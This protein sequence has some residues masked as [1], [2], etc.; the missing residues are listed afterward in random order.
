MAEKDAH[1][2]TQG[3]PAHSATKTSQ[4]EITFYGGPQMVLW[5]V[6]LFIVLSIVFATVFHVYSIE[7]L[8]LGAFLCL[9]VLWI[10][11]RDHL[12]FWNCMVRGLTSFGQAKLLFVFMVIGIF[13]K[14]LMNGKI[15]EGLVW[16]SLQW[17]IQG[18]AFTA[19]AF[20]GTAIVSLGCG[21]PFAAI[22]TGFSI[23]YAPGVLLGSNPEILAGAIIGGLYFGDTLAP[24]SQLT[25]GAL[26]TQINSLTG[27]QADLVRTLKQRI[28]WTIAAAVVTLILI[29]LIP[30]KGVAGG[31]TT[32]LA[33]LADPKGLWMLV[34]IAVVVVVCLKTKEIL[35]GLTF[36]IITGFG[37]GM[38]AG[39]FSFDDVI[40]F[41]VLEQNKI[42]GTI[43]D[44]MRSMMMM[45]VMMVFL[46]GI[47]NL[48][49]VS[50]AVDM[51]MGWLQK[52]AFFS[53]P[54]GAET[55][56]IVLNAL[57]NAFICGAALPGILMMGELTNRIGQ[58]AG[59]SP[60]RRTVTALTSAIS[61]SGVVP[62]NSI[63]VLGGI[64]VAGE[65]MKQFSGVVLP[66]AAGVFLNCWFGW[67]MTAILIL[68][69]I[70]GWG[71]TWEKDDP[72]LVA[73]AQSSSSA[74]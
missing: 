44:G 38:I 43:M 58:Q 29:L 64:S 18:A 32:A 72:D 61:L 59:I 33:A 1:N 47:I 23:F 45:A 17:N 31:D 40:K 69:I 14:L 34:P 4:P 63:F 67:L 5:M 70:T 37:V 8:T 56:I 36:G 68:W 13:S 21:V 73:S 10:F 48:M 50:G 16:L 20:V 30:E 19:F 35:T 9:G 53:T 66:N 24:S 6:V 65:A 74:H 54:Q 27:K 2:T 41:Q 26:G 60:E 28:P 42:A 49:K 11:A 52:V 25:F 62:F 39:V 46:A 3:S 15:G 55:A 22:F 7:G 57:M 71:R 51:I 12:Q